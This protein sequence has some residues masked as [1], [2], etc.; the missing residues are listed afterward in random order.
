MFLDESID[1]PMLHKIAFRWAVSHCSDSPTGR[2]TSPIY[3]MKIL[4]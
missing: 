3:G 1:S 4:I 2:D